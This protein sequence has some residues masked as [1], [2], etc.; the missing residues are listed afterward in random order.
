MDPVFP[1]NGEREIDVCNIFVPEAVSSIDYS[2][3]PVC[4]NYELVCITRALAIKRKLESQR[5]EKRR[6]EILNKRRE[7]QQRA[8]EKYQ[9]LNKNYTPAKEGKDLGFFY[10]LSFRLTSLYRVV[11]SC[12]NVYEL[13]YVHN[14]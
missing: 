9:R 6:Q 1:M 8:T 13:N 12:M 4:T 10:I 7:E 3:I 11:N 5:E 2:D 14:C